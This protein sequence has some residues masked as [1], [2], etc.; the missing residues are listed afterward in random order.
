MGGV[1]GGVLGLL[2]TLL[3]IV[4]FVRRRKAASAATSTPGVG[5]VPPMSTV[6]PLLAPNRQGVVP[7]NVPQSQSYREQSA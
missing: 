3:G 6:E 1:V 2:L 7:Y 5:D 4:C